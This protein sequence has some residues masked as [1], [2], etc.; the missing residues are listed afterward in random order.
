MLFP[1]HTDGFRKQICFGKGANDRDI[2]APQ[3]Q[4]A[5]REGHLNTVIAKRLEDREASTVR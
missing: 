4:I 3:M 1:A 5:L 2:Y